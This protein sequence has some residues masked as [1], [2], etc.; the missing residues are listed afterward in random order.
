MR[1]LL[2]L[3]VGVVLAGCGAAGV[4]TSGMYAGLDEYEATGAARQILSDESAKADSPVHRKAVLVG[5]AERSRWTDGTADA[6]RVE[7]L[8]LDEQ[9]T[10]LCVWVAARGP[11]PLNYNY[12]WELD[13]CAS[14]VE[15]A[16]A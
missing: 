15:D 5:R 6:W 7:V 12:A 3:V 4:E 1:P 10:G 2:V 9:P 13:R 16:A 11:D 14:G 8:T